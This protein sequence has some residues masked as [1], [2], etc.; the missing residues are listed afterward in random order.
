[1][2]MNKEKETDIVNHV[3]LCPVDVKED[4]QVELAL[5]AVLRGELI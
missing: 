2:Y 3:W 5:S 1:M 4:F